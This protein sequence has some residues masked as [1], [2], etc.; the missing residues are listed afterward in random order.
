MSWELPHTI[1]RFP[2]V[3]DCRSKAFINIQ[4]KGVGGPAGVAGLSASVQV[5]QISGSAPAVAFTAA[6]RRRRRKPRSTAPA[7]G[8][9]IDDWDDEWDEEWDECTES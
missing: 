7:L 3:I 2:D 9:R 6:A 8:E 4:S 5:K 1:D